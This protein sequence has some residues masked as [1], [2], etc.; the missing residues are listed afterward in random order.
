MPTFTD[1]TFHHCTLVALAGAQVSL[2]RPKFYAEMDGSSTAAT[3]P[4]IS[5]YSH[6]NGTLVHVWGGSITGGYQGLMVQDGAHVDASE[7]TVSRISV[8]GAKT[9]GKGS[10]LALTGCKIHEFSTA[11]KEVDCD[12]GV[13]A[14]HDSRLQMVACEIDVCGV[15]SCGVQVSARATLI[16][17]TVAGSLSGGLTV[18]G[19]GNSVNAEGCVFK[20][21]AGSG[22]AAISM[23][24][25]VA[26]NCKSSCN[27]VNGFSAHGRGSVV[28]L[29]DC[30]STDDNLGVR[31]MSGGKLTAES[32]RV[33]RSQTD[34]FS[35]VSGGSMMLKQCHAVS[36][37]NSGIVVRTRGSS[38]EAEDCHL[39]Q[40]QEFGAVASKGGRL[41]AK[42]CKS[43]QN[44]VA[45]YKVEGTG[46]L[47]QL[48]DCCSVDDLTGCMVKLHAWL[49]ADHVCVERSHKVGFMVSQGASMVLTECTA[50]K[51]RAMSGVIVNGSGSRVEA[52]RCEFS[53]NRESGIRACKGAIA[54]CDDN[55]E[56]CSNGSAGFIVS[57]VGSMMEVSNSASSGDRTG[58]HADFGGKLSADHVSVYSSSKKGYKVLSGASML[59]K[60]CTAQSSSQGVFVG[61]SCQVNQEPRSKSRAEAYRCQFQTCK[62]GMLAGQD[63][64]IV[65]ESCKTAGCTVA[66]YA[67]RHQGSLVTLTACSSSGD[68]YGFTAQKKGRLTAQNVAVDGSTE[69][70]SKV[71]TEGVVEMLDSTASE[72]GAPSVPQQPPVVPSHSPVEAS[73]T[74]AFEAKVRHNH[75][76]FCSLVLFVSPQT[77]TALWCRCLV[78]MPQQKMMQTN[79]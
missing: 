74:A 68:K 30:S 18:L 28:Q 14:F 65:A 67:A 24:H 36:S 60:D 56:T 66:G 47:A 26:H 72:L 52:H 79:A 78:M 2:T 57:G 19:S 38:V 40:N 69:A 48:T 63:G 73:T 43:L 59:L 41:N 11:N 27:K 62:Q 3:S 15:A 39:A 25:L 71:F 4:G 50:T 44:K 31:A 53:C 20:S 7:L 33:Y 70:V 75:T 35:V 8:I 17:C 46:T 6:G 16:D 55:C 61:G 32:V 21:N 23:G 77:N 5:V 42:T 9:S 64:I 49:F 51:T 45:G 12:G 1:V 29:T 37:K 22:A 13:M 54:V 76:K 34:G 58:C 10:C